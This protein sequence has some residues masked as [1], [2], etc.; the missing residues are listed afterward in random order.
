MCLDLF[1]VGY[2]IL[3]YL[4]CTSSSTFQC[5]VLWSNGPQTVAYVSKSVAVTCLI[6]TIFL[7]HSHIL[8]F[9]YC[10]CL[11]SCFIALKYLFIRAKIFIMSPVLA[12][13][14]RDMIPDTHNLKEERVNLADIFRRL[15]PWS[16]GCM[17][18]TSRWKR[19]AE[20]SCLVHSGQEA[21]QGN[22]VREE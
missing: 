3:R 15:S 10:L 5:L 2:L 1:V 22:D 9:T 11:I 20:Q 13:L 16:A 18:D 6:D 12:S 17:A 14:S 7:E 21:K 19:V 4:C 8:S